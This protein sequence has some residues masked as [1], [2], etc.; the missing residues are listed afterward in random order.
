MLS[1]TGVNSKRKYWYTKSVLNELT[2]FPSDGFQCH[3]LLHMFLA[4][5]TFI[6]LK[7]MTF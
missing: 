2:E 6:N 4:S 3:S 5:G 7:F 1:E